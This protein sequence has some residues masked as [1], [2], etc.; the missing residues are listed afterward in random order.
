[1]PGWIGVHTRGEEHEDGQVRMAHHA[2]VLDV[3]RGA[4]AVLDGRCVPVRL[5]IPAQRCNLMSMLV[6]S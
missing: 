4:G 3:E 2:E 1:M 5:G 6:A